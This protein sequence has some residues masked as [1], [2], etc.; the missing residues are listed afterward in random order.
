MKRFVYIAFAALLLALA[1]SGEIWAQNQGA[2]NLKVIGET[3]V[4]VLNAKGEKEIKRVPAVKV[5]PGDDVVYTLSYSNGGKEPADKVVIT[6]PVPEHMFY[7]EGSA[8]GADTHITFSV[9]NGKT[10]DLP[11]KLTVVDADG[12]ERPAKG[13]DYTHIRWALYKSLAPGEKGQVS[14]R[15]TLE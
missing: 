10:Y 13:S 4:E 2:I 12:K 1:C 9:D 6:N 14:F 7:R 15:A 8:S 3:E 5:V 11:E